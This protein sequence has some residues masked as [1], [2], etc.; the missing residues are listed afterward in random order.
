MTLAD[1][2]FGSQCLWAIGMYLEV[3]ELVR[4]NEFARLADDD[5]LRSHGPCGVNA[6]ESWEVT[7]RTLP[8]IIIII[9]VMPSHAPR[10]SQ[11]ANPGEG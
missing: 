8:T 9:V 5:F 6:V 1:D 10:P 2:G 11:T 4:V 7:A 3:R